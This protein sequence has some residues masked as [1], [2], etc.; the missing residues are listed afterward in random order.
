[1]TEPKTRTLD[2]PGATLTY[3]VREA[4]PAGAR[5]VLMMVGSPMDASGFA[6]LAGYFSDRTVVTYDPRG[7]GTQPAG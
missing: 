5:P 2:L 6:T 3:E 4:E 1:M 7:V